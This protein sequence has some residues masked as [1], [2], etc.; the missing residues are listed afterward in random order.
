[1]TRRALTLVT[2]AGAML[3]PVACRDDD[4]RPR[5]DRTA[6]EIDEQL[7][8]SNTAAAKEGLAAAIVIDVS[9]SMDDDVVGKD[10][11]KEPKI[12]VARRAAIDL[13]EQ[14][15]KYAEDH[16]AERVMLGL[17]EFSRRRG[18]PDCR[19]V[20]PM[21]PPDRKRAASAIATLEPDGGT[22]IGQA[23]ITAKLELDG[24]GLSR[25]H[26]LL[27]TD[28]ENTDG[29]RPE[30][31]AEAIG[32]RPD[33]ERPSMYFVAFD[34]EASRFARL[35]DAG[36]LVLPAANARELNQT[37]DALLSGKILVEK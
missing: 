33:A 32:R 1:M 36:G 3:L 31:V 20:I 10:G 9:G 7:T 24:T 30:H 29:F 26:L 12:E 27:V 19:P 13:V 34:I 23:M 8:P 4:S 21:G 2:L 5:E 11:R 18:E 22:P 14:F 37:L 35:R 15:A 17:Y 6:R 25:R 28:G 16:S